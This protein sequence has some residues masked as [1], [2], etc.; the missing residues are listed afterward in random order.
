MPEKKSYHH[1]NLAETLV[2]TAAKLLEEKGIEALS[3]RGVA[4]EAGVSQA[5]PYH[6]FKDRK[7]LLAAVATRGFREI[8]RRMDSRKKSGNS[9]TNELI[10][11]GAEYVLFAVDNP[12][13]FRLMFGPELHLY[14]EDANYPAA[15]AASSDSLSSTLR[16]LHPEMSKKKIEASYISAWALVHGLAT[17]MVDGRVTLQGRTSAERRKYV[18]QLIG[19]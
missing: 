7:A 2:I 15:A 17:L 16:S 14:K 11:I 12:N 19:G 8:T 6:H 10:D 4:R 9:D 3:L 18:K 1:G 5:A 13:L